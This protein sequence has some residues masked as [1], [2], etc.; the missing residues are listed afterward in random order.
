MFVQPPPMQNCPA[1]Q[2]VPQ[3][4]QWLGSVRGSMHASVH[5]MSGA[6][7]VAAQRPLAQTWPDAQVAPALPASLPH[8][9]VAPQWARSVLG[10]TQLPSQTTS[11]PG[12]VVAHVP[13]LQTSPFVHTW[14]QVPQLAL[15]DFVFAQ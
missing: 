12:Q 8:P 2:T 4:P 14:P 13:S 9:A 11:L 6:A 1:L 5:T 7:H 15:S 10:L 3:S